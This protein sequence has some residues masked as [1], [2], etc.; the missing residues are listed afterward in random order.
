M[1][2]RAALLLLL[3]VAAVWTVQARAAEQ[4]K[5]A[6][7]LAV[8]DVFARLEARFLT[9]CKAALRSAIAAGAGGR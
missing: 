4:P 6:A 3:L 9:G 2:N 5:P 8:G 7:P 1:M